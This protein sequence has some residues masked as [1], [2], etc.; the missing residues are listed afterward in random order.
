MTTPQNPDPQPLPCEK[1]VEEFTRNHHNP[2]VARLNASVAALEAKL[3]QA[4]ET[5]RLLRAERDSTVEA[6]NEHGKQLQ[7]QQQENEKLRDACSGLLNHIRERFP[8][9]FK[10]GGKG[11]TCPHHKAIAAALS[12]GK[13]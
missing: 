2:I 4:K 6:D 9:D 12:K 5:I 7:S 1:A 13:Q 8:D 11:F 10:P 3:G